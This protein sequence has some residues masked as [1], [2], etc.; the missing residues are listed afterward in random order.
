MCACNFSFDH[1]ATYDY[2]R[3]ALAFHIREGDV[4]AL[5]SAASSSS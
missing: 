2:C 3:V 1:G 5:T 4:E